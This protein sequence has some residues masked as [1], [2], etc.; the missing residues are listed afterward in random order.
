MFD[1]LI[2]LREA[3]LPVD[4][5]STAQRDVLASLTEH[6]TAV[7][8]SIQQRLVEADNNAEVLAH[9]LKLL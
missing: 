9:D 1:P 2:I 4:H 3:G 8:A 6:E 5:L 7:L